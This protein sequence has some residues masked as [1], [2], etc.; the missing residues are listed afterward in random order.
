MQ[1]KSRAIA[2]KYREEL[3]NQREKGGGQR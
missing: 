3:G 2:A 1:E